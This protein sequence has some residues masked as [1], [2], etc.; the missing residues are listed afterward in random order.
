MRCIF[1]GSITLS[2]INSDHFKGLE[3]V[4]NFKQPSKVCILNVKATKK[5]RHCEITVI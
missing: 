3:I 1:C 4:H 2:N 5:L